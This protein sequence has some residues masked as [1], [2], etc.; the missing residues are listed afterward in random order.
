MNT[1]TERPIN[2]PLFCVY[3]RDGALLG[4]FPTLEAAEAY[5]ADQM[6]GPEL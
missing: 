3:D 4:A 2:A 6:Y 5:S 1:I